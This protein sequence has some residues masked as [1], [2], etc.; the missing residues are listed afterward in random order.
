MTDQRTSELFGNVPQLFPKRQ[1]TGKRSERVK[2]TGRWFQIPTKTLKT[3]SRRFW[4]YRN[5]AIL[6][7]NYRN[8]AWKIG[9]YRNTANPNVP[10]LLTSYTIMYVHCLT[11][12]VNK[13]GV[14][15]KTSG[16]FCDCIVEFF[17]P[18]LLLFPSSDIQGQLV[19]TTGFSWAKGYNKSSCCK[20]SSMKIPSSRLA[21]P[22]SPRMYYSLS[23]WFS[24]SCKLT[25]S[26]ALIYFY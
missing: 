26:R 11:L 7:Q 22:G 13:Q 15:F 19:G 16:K 10:L 25:T 18:L 5:T 6:D 8:T 20:L 21:A 12:H 1:E 4:E 9:Q 17:C 24:S 3:E 23:F 2:I 14:F